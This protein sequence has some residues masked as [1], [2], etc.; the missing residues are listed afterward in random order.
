MDQ[1]RVPQIEP[2]QTSSYRVLVVSRAVSAFA[3]ELSKRGLRNIFET[4]LIR[5]NVL[6]IQCDY[7][8]TGSSR[9]STSHTNE[10]EYVEDE[11]GYYNV[12]QM[13]EGNESDKET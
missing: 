9:G 7:K 8:G 13:S 5:Y 1:S 6:P 3:S 10:R 11:V 4:L 2:V 12:S